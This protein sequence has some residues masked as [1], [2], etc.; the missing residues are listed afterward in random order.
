MVDPKDFLNKASGINRWKGYYYYKA[1]NVISTEYISEDKVIDFVLSKFS[2][3]ELAVLKDTLELSN[4][5]KEEI[6]PLQDALN[7]A[8]AD[9]LLVK[10][11]ET[12]AQKD[13]DQ[14]VYFFE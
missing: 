5:A 12:L 7:A 4:E 13:Y 3:T 9:E 11:A 6:K 8:K 14:K 1:G 10:G 2:K